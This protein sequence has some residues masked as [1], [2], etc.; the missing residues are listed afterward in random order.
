MFALSDDLI[1]E[2]HFQVGLHMVAVTDFRAL[3]VMTET[4]SIVDKVS[5]NIPGKQ[6]TKF[7]NLHI[8]LRNKCLISGLSGFKITHIW[9]KRAKVDV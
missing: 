9:F 3:T 7:D 5:A 1:G 2:S 4:E 8:I 6:L